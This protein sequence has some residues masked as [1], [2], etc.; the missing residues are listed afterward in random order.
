[1]MISYPVD[2]TSFYTN[3]ACML[4]ITDPCVDGGKEC[5]NSC[6]LPTSM[7]CAAA[8]D[9]FLLTTVRFEELNPGINWYAT[10][11][12]F[13]HCHSHNRLTARDTDRQTRLTI[14]DH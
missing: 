5:G 7:S 9:L 2:T 13:S 3:G 1:M 10:I 14:V 4:P 6:Q 12:L 8:A 11:P